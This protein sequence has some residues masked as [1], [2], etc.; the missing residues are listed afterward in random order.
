[1]QLIY[2]FLIKL[3]LLSANY[4]KMPISRDQALRVRV[5]LMLLRKVILIVLVLVISYWVQYHY[6]Y[7]WNLHIAVYNIQYW[8]LNSK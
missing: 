1:L 3:N 2:T 7:S 8:L 5:M 6:T 4:R